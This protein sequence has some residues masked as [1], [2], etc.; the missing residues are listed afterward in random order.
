MAATRVGKTVLLVSTDPAHSTSDV[1]GLPV[2]PAEREIL[3][4]LYAMEIDAPSEAHEYIA[5]VKERATALFGAA[6]A[7]RALKQID[8]AASMPGIEDAALFD[9]ISRIVSGQTGRHDL[10]IFDTAP[11]GH[12]LP[13]LR[14]PEAMTGWLHALAESRRAMLPDDRRET[15]QIIRALEERMERLQLFRARL[16]SRATTAFVLVLIPERLPIDETARAAEQ[17]GESGIDIGAIVVNQVV[18]DTATGEFIEARRRQERVH[19]ARIDRLFAGHRRV[20]VARRAAD[21]HG[22]EDL[23]AIAAMLF[24]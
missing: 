3:P 17:L 11:T 14:M 2:G 12:T 7:G 16:T 21:V 5:N 8:L 4:A 15:D 19:L 13:L 24:A 23:E 6:S 1:L 20:R 22:L 18:P 9:R 10:V